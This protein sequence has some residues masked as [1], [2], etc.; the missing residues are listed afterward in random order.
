MRSSARRTPDPAR[1]APT[2]TIPLGRARLVDVMGQGATAVV[3]AATIDQVPLAVKVLRPE[4]ADDTDA[5]ARFHWEIEVVDGLCHPGI[6]ACYG[7]GLTSEGLPFAAFHR[8][9]G[10][11]LRQKMARGERLSVAAALRALHGILEVLELTHRAGILHR[12]IK[13]SNIMLSPEGLPYVLDFGLIQSIDAAHDLRRTGG[14]GIVGTPAYMAP[15]MARAERDAFCP[16]TDLFC[17]ALTI[18]SGLA[19]RPLRGATSQI[20]LLLAAQQ[21]VGPLRTYGLSLPTALEDLLERALSHEIHG[22]FRNAT[23]MLDALRFAEEELGEAPVSGRI[24]R[25]S[26]RRVDVDGPPPMRRVTASISDEGSTASVHPPTISTF[27]PPQPASPEPVLP[28]DKGTTEQRRGPPLP[29]FLIA[30]AIGFGLF[31]ALSYF[32]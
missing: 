28:S 1:L 15:E 18:A 27:A 13:P 19:G 26:T 32:R 12:D 21:P 6:P 2:I 7:F 8:V 25:E 24:S 22:R 9:T 30:L 29:L 14:N 5:V 4:V 20:D 23:H 16:A 17:V 31:V 3:Y 11:T 10:E